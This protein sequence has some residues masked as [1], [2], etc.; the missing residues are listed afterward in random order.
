MKILA[1]IPAR[2]QSKGVPRKNIKPLGGRPLLAW[3]LATALEA[4]DLFA[5]VL[6]ST[7]DEEI[8]EVSRAYGGWVPFLRSGE[9]ASDTAKSIEVVR[10]VLAALDRRGRSYDAV[11]LLQPTAPFRHSSHLRAAHEKFVEN[12]YTGLVS[13]RRVPDHYH[14]N[15]T[16][17]TD[18]NDR[19][20]PARGRENMLPRRQLL[21]PAYYRDGSV[22]LTKT[23][24]LLH[25]GFFGERLGYSVSTHPA[26]INIDTPDDWA[27]A[28]A[29][30]NSNR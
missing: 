20:V 13:V 24:T 7:E 30:V 3:T 25:D 16:F 2:G 17:L 5:D 10:E 11:C 22:Y 1:L 14:P 23:A 29:W 4:E 12:D 27:A 21:P 8:A 19:L 6:V 15:W 18:E 9:T 28:E 26:G